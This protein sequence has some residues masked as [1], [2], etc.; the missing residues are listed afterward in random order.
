M[1]LERIRPTVAAAAA[2]ADKNNIIIIYY[3]QPWLHDQQFLMIW[4]RCIVF[5]LH[6]DFYLEDRTSS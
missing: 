5:Y 6:L 1:K 4:Y 3:T 2:A